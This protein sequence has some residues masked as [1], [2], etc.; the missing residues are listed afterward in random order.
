MADPSWGDLTPA[1]QD[2]LAYLCRNGLALASA[3]PAALELIGH[4]L[5][6]LT[7]GGA[8]QAPTSLGRKVW[9]EGTCSDR[10]A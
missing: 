6:R 8:D 2:R 5:I 1:A 10:S 3:D 9:E 7:W 4:G